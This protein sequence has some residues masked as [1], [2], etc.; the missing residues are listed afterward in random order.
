MDMPVGRPNVIY[1]LS[2]EHRGQ[3]MGH[4]GDVNVQ[5]PWMDRL[6]AQGAGFDRA[7][8]NCPICTPGRASI[9]SGR[10]AH[11]APMTTH[12]DVYKPAAPS[13]ATVLQDHGYYTAYFGKWHCGVVEDQIPPAMRGSEEEYW[14]IFRQRTPEHLRGGFQEWAAYEL[15]NVHFEGIVYRNN[16]VNPTR[17]DGYIA[18][19]VTDLAI[20]YMNSYN[21]S[22]PLFMVLSLDPPHFPMTVPDRF[23]RHDPHALQVRPNFVDSPGVRQD[24][25]TYYAMIENVDWNIG[26][27]MESLQKRERFAD[28]NTLVVYISDHGDF[29]GSHG[30]SKKKAHPHEESTRIPS[31][32]HWPGAFATQ[33]KTKGLFSL[34]D[35]M[36]TTLGLVGAA[37]P[38]WN[39]GIDFSPVLRGEPF[40]SP[41][42]VLLEVVGCPRASLNYMDW[43][44]YV[45]DRWKYAYYESGQQLLFDLSADPYEKRNLADEDPSICVVHRA[46]LLEL[47]KQTRE[48]FFDV[49]IEHGRKNI[50]PVINVSG[51]EYPVF[52]LN[53][54]KH[55]SG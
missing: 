22:E 30:L 51:S 38:P 43:R 48:P 13:T 24:L 49:L 32:F 34:V 54:V 47:L 6:A 19:G 4:A 39:Q 14:G 41:E 37:V 20:D 29:M 33:G 17:V 9:F 31:L 11:A 42:S 12:Y 2:D 36:A 5:T 16:D 3:A 35:L 26:R 25:A 53:Q 23:R 7:Y 45:S 28:S 1:I 55:V 46:H 21:R 52:G 44:G 18:D 50:E 8:A 40:N 10:H 27:L 15:V